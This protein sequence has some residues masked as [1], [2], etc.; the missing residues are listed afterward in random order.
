MRA[1]QRSRVAAATAALAVAVGSAFACSGGGGP[2]VT[3]YKS[4]TCGCCVEWMDHLEANG[5]EVRGVDVADMSVVKAERGVPSALGAC[6]TAVVEGYVI[7]G[8]VPASDIVRLLEERPR[9]TGLA[10]PGMPIGSP[11]M[12]GPNPEPFDVIAFDAAGARTF[13][14]HRP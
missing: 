7:E 9:V 8:H 2:L 14:I 1:S 10:T 13:S 6:H 5:F 3:V 4:P 11:G 12:E